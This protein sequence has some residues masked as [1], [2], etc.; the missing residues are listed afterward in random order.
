MRGTAST[1]RL[2]AAAMRS[3][4]NTLSVCKAVRSQQR[5]RWCAT[6]KAQAAPS[7]AHVGLHYEYYREIMQGRRRAIPRALEPRRS[8]TPHL[9]SQPAHQAT[10]YKNMR[11]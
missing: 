9:G 6:L 11:V 1:C 4:K 8:P 5:L 2:L 7:N 3:T 10:S